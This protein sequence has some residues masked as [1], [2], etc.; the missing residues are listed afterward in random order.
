[1]T[2]GEHLQGLDALVFWALLYWTLLKSVGEVL[3]VQREPGVVEPEAEEGQ[4]EVE[5]LVHLGL[6]VSD[7]G[8]Q[9]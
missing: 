5:L 4:Q 3:P 8:L 9:G 7:V 1:M 2:K 6:G